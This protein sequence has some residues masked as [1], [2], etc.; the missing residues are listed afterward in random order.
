MSGD[1]AAEPPEESENHSRSRYVFK[2][3][4]SV[5]FVTAFIV[6]ALASY[7]QWWA[8]GPFLGGVALG[9]GLL[10][11]MDHFI[12]SAFT[13]E[14]AREAKRTGKNASGSALVIFTLV[15]YPLVALLLWAATRIWDLQQL[16]VFAGGFML[17]QAVIALRAVG[18]HLTGR[19]SSS[20][21]D[22]DS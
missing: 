5:A 11:G 21:N 3:L 7:G 15:K 18:G 14:K 20:S 12:R 10:F 2:T 6:F 4:R 9:S 16:M 13:P 22:T 19:S 1:G 8:I 17:I